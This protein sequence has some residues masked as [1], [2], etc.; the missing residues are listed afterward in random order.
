[1]NKKLANTLKYSLSFALA[2]VLLYFSFRNVSWHEFIS[3]LRQTDWFFVGLSMCISLL[4]F[5]LRGLRWN[6]LL[7]PLDPSFTK[8]RSIEGVCFGNLAN[9]II[10]FSGEFARSGILATKKAGFTKLLGTVALERSWDILLFFLVFALVFIFDWGGAGTFFAESIWTPLPDKFGHGV[11]LLVLALA[12]LAAAAVF[13][14][15]RL[16]DRNKICARIYGGAAGVLQGFVSFTKIKNKLLFVLYSVAIWVCYWF[17]CVCI[18]WAFAPVSHLTVMDGL[19]IMAAGSISSVI[20]APGGF[21]TYHYFVTLTLLG[22]FDI[23]WD[24][25]IIYATLTHEAQAVTMF[26]SG[27]VSYGMLLAPGKMKKKA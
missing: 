19:M 10:P 11:W 21:G 16:K 27:L 3:G 13:A 5:V 8:L 2:A 14:V 17:A 24:T 22:L 20:P 1:M 12:V 4:A 18:L 7:K 15:I 25:G 6:M 23:P 26:I 9:C